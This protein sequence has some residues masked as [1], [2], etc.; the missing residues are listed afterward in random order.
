MKAVESNDNKDRYEI[1]KP[2]TKSKKKIY[3]KE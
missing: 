1:K 2:L 3:Q